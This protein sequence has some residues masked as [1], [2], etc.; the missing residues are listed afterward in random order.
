MGQEL[1]PGVPIYNLPFVYTFLGPIDADHFRR[2]FQALIEC[3]DA[4]RTVIEVVDGVPQQRVLSGLTYSLEYLDFSQ[5]A[6]GE[7]AWQNC[8]RQRSTILF[9]LEKCLFDSVLAKISENRFAWYLN[10]HHLIADGWSRAVVLHRMAELY[11]R[12]QQGRLAHLPTF[13]SFQDYALHERAYRGTPQYLED[14]AYWGQRLAGG[15]PITFYGRAPHRQTTGVDRVVCDLGMDRTAKLKA[16]SLQDDLA[17]KTR[18]ASAFNV[19]ASIFATYIYHISGS[20]QLTIGTP[21]L[22]R[23]SKDFRET[24]GLFTQVVPLRIEISENETV[25]SLI[26]KVKSQMLESL[27][28]ARCPVNNFNNNAFD[29]VFNFHNARYDE[30]CGMPVRGD[31]IHPGHDNHSLSLQVLNP[32]QTDGSYILYF[33]FHSD[34]FE[35]AQRDHAVR[36]F[37]RVL[38]SFLDDKNQPLGCI[39]L[40]SREDR[41]LVRQF[42]DTATLFPRDQCVH[43]LF[44]KHVE[45]TPDA[46]A[47][48]FGT[49]QVTYRELNCRANQLAHY[50]RGLGVIPDM[51]VG[52]CLNQSAEFVVGVLGILKAGGAY[53]PLDPTYPPERLAFMMADARTPIVV[54]HELEA[55]RFP[56]ADFKLVRIDTDRQTIADCKLDNPA[57]GAAAGNLAYVMYTS[58]STGKPKGVCIPHRAVNRLVCNANYVQLRSSD[59]MAQASSCSFDAATFEI[60]GALLN[61]ARLVGI[62]RDVLL[63]PDRLATQIREQGISVLFLTTALFNQLA[64]A[65][66]AAFNSVRDLLFGGE[67]ADP[68]AVRAVLEHGAPQRLLNMYGPTESTTFASWYAIDAMPV[69]TATIPI[70]RPVVNTEL[71]VL[72]SEMQLAAT[73]VPG[74]LYIGGDGLA[75]GYLNQPALT[76][77]RFVPDPFGANSG[78]RL[79]KTGDRVRLRPDGNLEFLGR[80]DDQVKIRGFRIELGEIESVL[81]QHPKVRQ[82]VVSAYESGTDRR[83]AAYLTV[84]EGNPPLV[85][86]LR[87]C[88]ANQL[89]NYMVPSAFTILDTLPLTQNGK[90]DRRALPMPDSLRP[91]L[92]SDYV[93]PRNL[94]EERLVR[95]WQELLGIK[96]VGITDN[97]FDLGGDSL[98]AVRMLVQVER[99]LERKVCMADLFP[100]PTIEQLA[101][102]VCEATAPPSGCLLTLQGEGSNWPLFCVTGVN[103]HMFVFRQLV[104]YLGA[105]RP[106]YGLQ[107]PGLDGEREPLTSVEEIAAE[108][109]ESIR[110]IR[111]EGP[112][113]LC[114][115]S[116]GGLVAYEIAQQLTAQRY[117]VAMLA[118]FDCKA[119]GLLPQS[120]PRNSHKSAFSERPEATGC[121]WDWIDRV[122]RV[123]RQAANH[124]QARPYTG[125]AILFRA[126]GQAKRSDS[127][128]SRQSDLYNGWRELVLGGLELRLVPGKH[129]RMFREP[130]VLVLA[131]QLL[132]YL[133]ECSEFT[134]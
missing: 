43:E 87:R 28:H 129:K 102:M 39:R 45:R 66:P 63:S 55:E 121:L 76:A 49:Q 56:A 90:V 22:N 123:N 117:P 2:A 18:N 78:A 11:E 38:D 116:F 133:H 16:L 79:Y 27:Q 127:R 126:T 17:C 109:I 5:H 128:P 69:A 1:H 15:A 72:N 101:R 10:W 21:V 57:S 84:R 89:P 50:L 81:L 122:S 91:E 4:M 31:R 61:G 85:D 82:C 83:L 30:F 25:V 23:P 8:I 114:G 59:R 118:F 105:E 67:V 132:D 9:E 36:H 93:A 7:A 46:V 54:T 6:A 33:D 92:E 107:Y 88:L 120:R 13:P 34:V 86:E 47:L 51:P 53:L 3:T 95:I 71:Y 12:S 106:V 94:I 96:P 37:L 52:I 44:E 125:R 73:G 131:E 130:N 19:L 97:F 41:E 62:A 134:P 103:G 124:Y 98:L 60:W 104:R 58:G 48:V 119:P 74:D 113:H 77:E 64:T 42:N 40:V 65:I 110:K 24:V 112:C 26:K 75:L 111:P 68:N 35:A 108:F 99:K 115:F 20:R 70:G 14:Q 80:R 29:V 32:D 100:A